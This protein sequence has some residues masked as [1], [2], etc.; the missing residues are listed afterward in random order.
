[1]TFKPSIG[2]SCLKGHWKPRQTAKWLA[3]L[4]PSVSGDLPS[5]LEMASTDSS[6]WQDLRGPP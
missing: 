6:D 2:F 3:S 4:F 5:P 1:M